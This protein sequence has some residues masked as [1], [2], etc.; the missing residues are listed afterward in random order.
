MTKKILIAIAVIIVAALIAVSVYFAFNDTTYKV[1]V[2]KMERLSYSDNNAKYL[3]YCET[4]DGETI[5]FENEAEPLRGKWSRQE[6]NGVIREG[7]RETG[8]KSQY[9]TQICKNK[10]N[11]CFGYSWCYAE[12]IEECSD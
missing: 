6:L 10:F 5:V 11:Q 12:E 7:E 3:I 8:I 9:I 1:T 4:D 2:V